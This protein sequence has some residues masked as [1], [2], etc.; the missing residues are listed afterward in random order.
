VQDEVI[1]KLATIAKVMNTLTKSPDATISYDMLAD[2][3]WWSD[4][5]PAIGTIPGDG[6]LRPVVHYRT[7]VIINKPVPECL[8]YWLAAKMKFPNW[9][10]FDTERCKPDEELAA[11]YRK[12][13]T[14]GLLSL[15]LIDI[16][17]RLEKQ[18]QGMV[19][20]KIIEK[21]AY[22]NEPPDITAGELCDLT[23]RCIRLA[24][25]EIPADAWERVRGTVAESLA[26][27]PDLVKK[28]SWLVR[29]LSAG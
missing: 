4:E 11:L 7:S 6:C 18:F 8:P 16:I 3:L 14:K 20:S 5:L 23:C 24:G 29:D 13:K 9:P 17:C 1:A 15:N 2:A 21:H 19:P 22:Q 25:M 10:G 26:I 12:S 27:A 28:D